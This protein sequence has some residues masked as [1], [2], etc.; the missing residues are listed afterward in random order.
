[1]FETI[2]MFSGI[3]GGVVALLSIVVF[4]LL[5]RKFL[6]KLLIYVII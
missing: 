6:H 4:F 3:I 5:K 1:M 2:V